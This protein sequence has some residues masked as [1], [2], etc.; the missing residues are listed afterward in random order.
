LKDPVRVFSSVERE[1]HEGLVELAEAESRPMY[2]MIRVI[3][4]KRVKKARR[5]G[6]IRTKTEVEAEA[7]EQAEPV[8]AGPEERYG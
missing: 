5:D 6:E 1:I 8:L 4:T 7:A 2:E 3:L